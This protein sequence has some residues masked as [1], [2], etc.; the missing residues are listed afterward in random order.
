MI[1]SVFL[2]SFYRTAINVSSTLRCEAYNQCVLDGAFLNQPSMISRFAVFRN[3]GQNEQRVD[4]IV[5]WEVAEC[6]ISAVAYTYSSVSVHNNQFMAG[7]IKTSP[8]VAVTSISD[9]RTQSPYS[10][11]NLTTVNASQTF[12][13]NSVD[14]YAVH[15][16]LRTM[17]FKGSSLVGYKGVLTELN[18]GATLLHKA[19]IGKVTS[20]IALGMTNRIRTG[21][22]STVAHGASLRDEPFVV[23]QWIWLVLPVF[24]VLASTVFLQVTVVLNQMHDAVL[25]KSSSVALLSRQIPDWSLQVP[26]NLTSQV[27]LKA[28]VKSVRLVLSK[29]QNLCLVD[30]DCSKKFSIL[31]VW[32][33]WKDFRVTVVIII[34][35]RF[36]A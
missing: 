8:L 7:L 30:T 36:G 16:F 11:L 33:C 3:S 23:V 13:V 1:Q 34:E 18:F 24:T 14:W 22:N 10:S 15:R 6:N 28:A 27:E 35:C 12:T 17:V 25:W 5:L 19:D 21:L 26:E 31:E 32:T 2:P 29:D 4:R 20:N 9:N